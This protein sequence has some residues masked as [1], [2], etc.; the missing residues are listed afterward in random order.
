[1]QQILKNFGALGMRRLAVM[2]AV[3]LAVFAAIVIGLGVIMSPAYRPLSTDLTASEAAAMVASLEQAGFTPSISADGTVISLPEQDLARA[4]MA[5]AEAGLPA[6][7]NAGWEIFDNANG[8]GMNSF[9]QR[10]NRL[11]ALEG[12]LAR[13]AQTIES[14]EAA[15]VHL[16]LPERE[17][18]SQERP[19]PSASVILKTRRG[20]TLERKHAIAVRNLVASAVP[21]MSPE[22]VVVLSASGEMILGDEDVSSG[23]GIASTRAALED[24]VARSVESIIA[25]HVG[26]GNVRVRVS[27]DI[28]TQRQVVVQES[29]DADQQV[30]RSTS[31]LEERSQGQDAGAGNVDVANNMPGVENGNG[32]AGGRNES[33]SKTLDEITYEIGNTRSET[34]TDPGSVNRLTVAVVVNGRMEGENYVERTEEEIARITGLVRTAAGVDEER[35]DIVTVESLR[36]VD[37]MGLLDAETGNGGLNELFAR[38]SGTIIRGVLALLGLFLVLFF[39]AR[40]ALS[41]RRQASTSA[42]SGQ[43]APE[44]AADQAVAG[45]SD[46]A[47]IA[48]QAVNPDD[49]E[50]VPIASVSGNVT[51]RYIDELKDLVQNNPDE[52]VRV[53]RSWIRQKA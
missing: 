17:T 46:A 43:A 2:G 34:V 19:E 13:S 32:A 40:P 50:Y 29:F 26:A 30:P 36:F 38:N 23:G 20:M 44:I 45:A 6:A 16:V 9:L 42:E 15:R 14:V 33:R 37:D 48:S 24:R 53:I 49:P 39:V 7:G 27:A 3:G 31:A 51:K 28:S 11:R 8:I 41:G 10:I 5:L 18:F 35:G 1:M 47:T 4:R 21:G 22:S 12:E 25:A 52:A